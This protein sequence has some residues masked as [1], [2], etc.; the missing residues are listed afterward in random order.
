MDLNIKLHHW[1]LNLG[2]DMLKLHHLVFK[3]GGQD[4]WEK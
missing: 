4:I 3:F 2:V 1:H